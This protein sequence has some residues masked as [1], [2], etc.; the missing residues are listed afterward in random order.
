[1]SVLDLAEFVKVLEAKFGVSAAAPVMVASN[2]Y[3]GANSAAPAEEEKTSFDVVLTAPGD[4]KI[5]VIKI[6]KEI[7]QKGLKES[8]DLV[9]ASA[10]TPQVIKESVKRKKPKNLKIN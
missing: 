9:D 3:A 6:V 7:T 10:T 1:M 4:K 5:E 8:K 2:V